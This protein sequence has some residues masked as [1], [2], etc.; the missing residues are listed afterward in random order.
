MLK[1]LSLAAAVAAGLSTAPVAAN[2]SSPIGIVSGGYCELF[3]N[4][5]PLVRTNTDF[6]EC[7]RLRRQ[8]LAPICE[9]RG[10]FGLV[11]YYMYYGDA[12]Q[13]DNGDVTIDVLEQR[14]ILGGD[15]DG[16]KRVWSCLF[17]D[18]EDADG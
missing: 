14:R 2:A 7:D 13:G 18:D 1:K 17:S 9:E 6:A 15:F 8:R 11:S 5:S 12:S 3:I 16:R 4:N 10:I